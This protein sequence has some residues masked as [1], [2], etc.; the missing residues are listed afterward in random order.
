MPLV[1]QYIN[2]AWKLFF[3]SV[4]AFCPNN[5][6]VHI[7]KFIADKWEKLHVLSKV[8]IYKL[9]ICTHPSPSLIKCFHLPVFN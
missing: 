9:S 8:H 3:I 1:S 5:T 7:Y 6:E 2:L 4:I